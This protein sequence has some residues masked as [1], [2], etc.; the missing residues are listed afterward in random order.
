MCGRPYSLANFDSRNGTYLRMVEEGICYDCAHWSEYELGENNEIIGGILFEVCPAQTILNPSVMLGGKGMRYILKRDFTVVKS[1][2]IWKIA[3]IPQNF[4]EKFADT[5]WFISRQFY[6]R[7]HRTQMKCHS[8]GCM[9]RY[10]CFRYDYREEYELGA[11]NKVPKD[12]TVGDENCEEFVNM[13]DIK[14]YDGYYDTNDLLQYGELEDM[15]KNE[16]R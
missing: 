7:W 9:D 5:G 4:R 13:L 3:E 11:Y 2:D 12:W 16:D 8:R 15:N 14:R 1:N 10:H 6:Y